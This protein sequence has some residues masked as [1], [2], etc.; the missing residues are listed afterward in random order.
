M[1]KSDSP[2]YEPPRGERLADAANAQGG[3]ADGDSPGASCQNGTSDTSCDAGNL[4]S[5]YCNAGSNASG[6][7]QG[8]APQVLACSPG[9]GVH[10]L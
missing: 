10:A 8:T 2:K 5:A 4:A 6:C 3:C 7:D 9:S 1:T